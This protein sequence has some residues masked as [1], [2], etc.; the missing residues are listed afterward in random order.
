MRA[1]VIALVLVAAGCSTADSGTDE[2]TSESPPEVTAVVTAAEA[3]LGTI[4]VDGDGKTLYLFTP[5]EGGDSSC[6]DACAANWPPLI[7][8]V[9]AGEGVD[10]SMLGETERTDGST[11]ATYGGWPLYYFAGDASPG[12][13]SGQ[14]VNAVWYVVSPAGDAI[15]D[16]G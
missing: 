13:T 3:E 4:L 9:S 6:Y 14:G 15:T 5:D 7:G 12:D 2:G 10:G 1:L 16:G 11:Q 8:S